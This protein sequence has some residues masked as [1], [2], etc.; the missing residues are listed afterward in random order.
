MLCLLL[1]KSC[2]IHW[3]CP[4]IGF[5][6]TWFLQGMRPLMRSFEMYATTYPLLLV[7]QFSDV[8]NQVIISISSKSFQSNF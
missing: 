6:E 4:I 2:V 5:V 3:M 1:K 8:L 7:H